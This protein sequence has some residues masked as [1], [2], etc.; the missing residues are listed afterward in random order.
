MRHEQISLKWKVYQYLLGFT[1]ILLILLWLF[2]TVYLDSFYTVIKKSELE[3][4]LKV[5]IEN[6]GDDDLES[7]INDI[8]EDYEVYIMI[9]SENGDRLYSSEYY[10]SF[11]YSM[12]SREKIKEYFIRSK[13]T[14]KKLVINHEP[15]DSMKEIIENSP[16][17]PVE[18]DD[19]E[20]EAPDNVRQESKP[21]DFGN[22]PI[23]NFRDKDQAYQNV[24]YASIATINEEECIVMVNAQLTPVDATVHTIQVQL[25]CISII[26]I[27]LSLMIAFLVSKKISRSIVKV[28]QTAKELANGNF[29]V[30]LSGKDYK[31]I[32]ELSDTLNYTATE[33][34]RSE[35]LQKELLANGTHE[36]RTPLTMIIAYSEVM[37]DL[38]GEN[39]PENIQVV[40]DESKRLTNLVNDMLDI[41]KLQAGVIEN[42][43]KEYNLTESIKQVITR[44]SKLIEQ[45]GFTVTFEYGEN[46]WIEADEFK[47]YQVIYNL[48]SNAINYTGEDKKVFVKQLIAG[49]RVR[50]EVEDTGIGIEESDIRYVWE[51]YYKVDKTHKRAVVGIVKNIL[52]LY[53][54]KYGVISEV[55]CGS[56]FWFELEYIK[57]N[58]NK[59]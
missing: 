15:P 31:E 11:A 43:K 47:I 39:T 26:M 56:T 4:A 20:F 19:I 1:A 41:S 54:A 12:I 3:Q 16:P 45:N 35:N 24:T 52:D 50:I 46:V 53:Q 32:T 10:R 13:E 18:H 34:S 22:K 42:K 25:I 51:R 38:P 14:G 27:I 40:I 59:V 21:R 28:N 17:N 2:Q 48:I 23:F 29:K 55:N 57:I 9:G 7:V 6:L 5:L 37:R 58:K 30:E 8:S 49:D 36:L 44:Y 33:L